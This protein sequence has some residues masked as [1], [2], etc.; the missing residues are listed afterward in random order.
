M[1]MVETIDD[2][3]LTDE[4][5]EQTIPACLELKESEV[6]GRGLFARE[7]I[8]K[9]TSFKS[10]VLGRIDINGKFHDYYWGNGVLMDGIGFYCNGSCKFFDKYPVNEKIGPYVVR[11]I[12]IERRMNSDG[13]FCFI[14][15]SDI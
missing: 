9:N 12:N 5:L 6:A 1:T 8:P 15:T 10:N 7:F 4:Q 2:N 11:R 14:T 13:T 3:S